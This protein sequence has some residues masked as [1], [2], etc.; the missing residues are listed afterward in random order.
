MYFTHHFEYIVIVHLILMVALA[1]YFAP[2]GLVLIPFALLSLVLFMMPG[3]LRF[4]SV[5]KRRCAALLYKTSLAL[6]VTLFLLGAYA[7]FTIGFF[8][9]LA[10]YLAGMNLAIANRVGRALKN[11]ARHPPSPLARSAEENR[12]LD[13]AGF[14]EKTTYFTDVAFITYVVFMFAATASQ[15]SAAAIMALWTK[16]IWPGFL[17]VALV[18]GVR[19]LRRRAFST[20]TQA[21]LD[22]KGDEATI[23]KPAFIVD[24]QVIP[25]VIRGHKKKSNEKMRRQQGQFSGETPACASVAISGNAGGYWQWILFFVWFGFTLCGYIYF[26]TEPFTLSAL[27]YKIGT[28]VLGLS[29]AVVLRLMALRIRRAPQQVA[30]EMA[31]RTFLDRLFVIGS[32]FVIGPLLLWFP[33]YAL[34]YTAHD[35]TAQKTQETQQVIFANNGRPCVALQEDKVWFCMDKAETFAAAMNEGTDLSFIMQRSIFG[36]SIKGYVPRHGEVSR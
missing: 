13:A 17:V 9:L 24:D 20:A 29:S 8:G 33:L 3:D 15:I 27:S 36:V 14:W 31:R 6:N 34:A 16:W 26:R 30:R 21:A 28:L 32:L 10:W 18:V 5:G 25:A 22:S 7:L 35:L 4:A 23:T 1:V 11:I 12:A 2:L 19:K